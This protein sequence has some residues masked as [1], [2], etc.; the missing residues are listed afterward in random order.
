MYMYFALLLYYILVKFSYGNLIDWFKARFNYDWL[1]IRFMYDR[2]IVRLAYDLIF[3]EV[4]LL[5]DRI[6]FNRFIK[7]MFLVYEQIKVKY[8]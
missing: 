6:L 3:S 1:I 5:N 4:C 8:I 2:L 7:L